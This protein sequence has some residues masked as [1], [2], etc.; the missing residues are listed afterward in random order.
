MA[1]KTGAKY[2]VIAIVPLACL[3]KF[4]IALISVAGCRS[5]SHTSVPLALFCSA[6]RAQIISSSSGSSR[7]SN[8]RDASASDLPSP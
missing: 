6:G 8:F 1:A 5:M 3:M 7:P 4:T 2:V